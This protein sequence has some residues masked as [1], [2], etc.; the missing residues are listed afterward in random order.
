MLDFPALKPLAAD[1]TLQEVEKHA[2]DLWLSYEPLLPLIKEYKHNG[3]RRNPLP[4]A[5][6]WQVAFYEMNSHV[7]TNEF[8]YIKSS[9]ADIR[10]DFESSYK[11]V[12]LITGAAGQGK[13]NLLCDL[14]ENFIAKHN[15]P[16][17]FVSGRELGLKGSDS[18]AEVLR[19]HLFGEKFPTLEDGFARLSS[20]ALKSKKPFVLIIDG[21]NEHRDIGKFSQQLEMVVDGL[22]AYP[23]IRF[24]F[25][26]RTEFFEDRFSNLVQGVLK[27]QIMLCRSTESRLSD[28][29]REEL[30]SVYFEY[31]D[32]DGRRVAERVSKQLTTDLLLLRFFCEGYGKRDKEQ[33]YVQ[34]DIRHFYRDELF[35]LYLEQKLR[36][37]AN[38]LQTLTTVASPVS[39]LGELQSILRLCLAYML[40]RGQ[41]VAVPFSEVPNELRQALYALLDEELIIRKD[42]STDTNDPTSE[43]VNFTFDELRDF[44]FQNISSRTSSLALCPNLTP[45][46]SATPRKAHRSKGF[47]DSFSMRRENRIMRTSSQNTSSMIGIRRFTSGKCSTSTSNTWARTML[48]RLER[49]SRRRIGKVVKSHEPWL[50]VGILCIGLP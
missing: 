23:G 21:L 42:R 18:L 43:S 30:L 48:K 41:F 19:T 27:P 2:Q 34:P 33:G 31:F 50:S 8:Q 12:L 11:R 13:T 35:A 10:E 5:T 38:F 26:C 22:L 44:L 36:K 39:P 45:L 4:N 25:S 28:E 14:Y 32:V 1:S 40:K 6:P 49:S 3:G 20:E 7:L 37:A 29:A 24:L 46:S 17:A 47:S 9:I 15:I 16:C